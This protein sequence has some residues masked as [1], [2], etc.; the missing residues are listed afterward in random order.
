MFLPSASTLLRHGSFLSTEPLSDL[1]LVGVQFLTRYMQCIVACSGKGYVVQVWVLDW[2]VTKQTLSQMH[3]MAK[4]C[5]QRLD[6]I[7]LYCCFH[8]RPAMADVTL[9]SLMTYQTC[10]QIFLTLLRQEAK[11]GKPRAKSSSVAL[12]ILSSHHGLQALHPLSRF[13]GITLC[14]HHGLQADHPLSRSLV[15][16]SC[17]H[18]GLWFLRF[19]IITVCFHHHRFSQ[20]SQ[21]VTIT[22]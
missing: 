5:C 15:S 12:W 11:L 18:H 6:G 8:L 17:H 2:V 19:A 22:L 1:V 14:S 10:K 20:S 16:T 4:S 7:Q 21:T 13:P 9:S 3:G